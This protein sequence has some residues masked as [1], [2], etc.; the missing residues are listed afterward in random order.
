LLI[1]ARVLYLLAL[2]VWLGEVL[3]LSFVVAPALFT[4]FPVEEA[5]RAVGTLFP[6]YYKI[7]YVSGAVMLVAAL[8]LRTVA[9]GRAW[10]LVAGVVAVMLVVT[11]YAG[12]VIEP[13]ARALRPE[14]H[15]ASVAPAVKEEF[16]RLHRR[17][18]QLNGI[19]LLGGLAVAVISALQ[20]KP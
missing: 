15:A 8:V 19:V 14:L 11:L 7:G 9:S 16:D 12:I 20:L 5:G 6:I 1:A 3:F 2:V 18:V 10:A 13:R 17:A 4:T